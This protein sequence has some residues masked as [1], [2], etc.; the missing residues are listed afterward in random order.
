MDAPGLIRDFLM[1]FH[2]RCRDCGE[3]ATREGFYPSF[4]MLPVHLCDA[5]VVPPMVYIRDSVYASL[6]RNAK[7]YLSK[8]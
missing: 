8:L 1:C 2:I 4:H 5:C 6:I 7:E 3:P